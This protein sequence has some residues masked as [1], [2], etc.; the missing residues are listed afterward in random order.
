MIQRKP[1]FNRSLAADAGHPTAF[2]IE[3]PHSVGVALRLGG[4]AKVI[5]T[6]CTDMLVA[7]TSIPRMGTVRLVL[8]HD[9]G[10]NTEIFSS[11]VSPSRERR[12]SLLFERGSVVGYYPESQHDNFAHLRVRVGTRDSQDIFPDDSLATFFLGA[13]QRFVAGEPSA[14]DFELN[15]RIVRLLSDAKDLVGADSADDVAG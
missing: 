12:I 2:D 5:D 11:L 4:D 6:A 3:L 7:G 10:A 9:D 13:Y 14:A 1:R 15:V 8:Q